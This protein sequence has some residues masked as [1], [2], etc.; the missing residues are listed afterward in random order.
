MHLWG[1]L[2]SDA[3]ERACEAG[4]PAKRQQPSSCLF[5]NEDHVGSPTGAVR[6]SL[7]FFERRRKQNMHTA[8]YQPS[9]HHRPWFR[10]L[11]SSLTLF[12][13]ALVAVAC[14]SQATTNAP[15]SSGSTSSKSG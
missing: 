15:S 3:H 5:T 14:A 4:K 13:I 7:G 8:L 6:S 2:S 9:P 11:L 12:V 10:L 1:M